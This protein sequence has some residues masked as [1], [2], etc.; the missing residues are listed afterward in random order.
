MSETIQKLQRI[1]ALPAG[2]NLAAAASFV[3]KCCDTSGDEV[4]K[5][6]ALTAH[7]KNMTPAERDTVMA[8]VEAF[9]ANQ[10]E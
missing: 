9:A 4:Q 10:A 6:L 8:L 5:F 3:R 1:A 7:T 2:K